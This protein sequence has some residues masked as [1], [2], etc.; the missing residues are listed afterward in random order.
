MWIVRGLESYPPD[1]SPVVA[2]LGTFDGVHLAHR[3]ILAKALARGRVLAL[4]AITC[5]F[6]PHPMEVLQPDR[7]P[8][9]ISTLA[10]RLALIAGT[11]VD[12]ALVLR[13][14]RELA[15]IEAE[16]FVENILV[17][18]LK[19]REIVVGYN[20]TFGRGARGDVSLLDALGRR[21]GFRVH[22]MPPFEADGVP[23]SSTTIRTAL[24]AGN[25]E[26]AA[27]LLGRSYAVV[28]K[29]V[30]GT[31]RGRALG[32]PTANLALDRPL[33]AGSG[34]YACE[35][36]L[37]GVS[38][39]A[40]VNIGVRPT[41]G[42]DRLAVEAHLLDQSGDLYGRHIRLGFLRRLR[43]EQRFP[44]VDALRRQIAADVEAAR[45]LLGT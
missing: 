22:V 20:H 34:V 44:S 17:A 25:V 10:E 39:H 28:G 41:F 32:F 14:T 4:P 35:A 23:V 31:G 21:L 7:A 2:A 5:T 9:P 33:L 43:D 24:Q 11:G 19:V 6:D 45:R 30:R 1:A 18:R 16:A 3:A 27:R 29:V 8:R 13:F 40:V 36:E 42:E 12:G 26:A 38:G 37:D 15:A